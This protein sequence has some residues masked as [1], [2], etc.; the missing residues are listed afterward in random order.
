MPSKPTGA[1]LY[2]RWLDGWAFSSIS[3]ECA[4]MEWQV[5]QTIRLYLISQDARRKRDV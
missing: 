3:R 5:E 4:L 2:K 1:Q